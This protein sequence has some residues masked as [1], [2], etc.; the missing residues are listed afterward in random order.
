MNKLELHPQSHLSQT[1][2]DLSDFIQ[3]VRN[4]LKPAAPIDRLEYYPYRSA[5]PAGT[6]E[7]LADLH[8]DIRYE[9]DDYLKKRIKE[10]VHNKYVSALQVGADS[11]IP[12]I[13]SK[14]L[15]GNIHQADNHVVYLLKLKDNWMYLQFSDGHICMGAE[16]VQSVW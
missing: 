2:Y 15:R 6:C 1:P 8:Y 11:S 9:L 12:F 14:S 4:W 13:N 5:Y 16:I 10:D 3:Y 7:L